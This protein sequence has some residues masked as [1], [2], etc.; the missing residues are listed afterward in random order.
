MK[1]KTTPKTPPEIPQASVAD[2]AFLLLIFFIATTQFETEFGIPLQ[3]PG[4]G[5]TSVKVKSDNVLAI[6]T[7]AD[8]L[9]YV[10][11]EV[12]SLRQVRDVV[13]TELEGNANLVVVI[14]TAEDAPYESM[15]NVLDE[16]KVAKAERIS[17]KKVRK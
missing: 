12:V 15:V 11:D 8:G 13:K 1:I 2:V 9:V 3:L 4:I 7:S 16:V 17:I 6:K 10:R 5:T 14:E